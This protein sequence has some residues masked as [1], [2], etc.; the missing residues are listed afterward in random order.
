[1]RGFLI[2][3]VAVLVAIGLGV[4]GVAAAGSN[5]PSKGAARTAPVAHGPVLS[6]AR[7]AR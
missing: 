7:A 2:L 5:G 6:A 4:A 1:M 3:L